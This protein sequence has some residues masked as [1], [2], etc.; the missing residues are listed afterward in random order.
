MSEKRENPFIKKT[1][2]IVAEIFHRGLSNKALDDLSAELSE[3]VEE[4]DPRAAY[5][6]YALKISGLQA[7]DKAEA[8]YLLKS[9]AVAGYAPAQYDL[10]IHYLYGE[11]IEKDFLK[12]VRYMEKAGSQN[13][14][15]AAQK[16]VT[17]YE[18]GTRIA[19]NPYRAEYWR[20]V[21]EGIPAEDLGYLNEVSEEQIRLSSENRRRS[22]IP[23][24]KEKTEQDK[25]VINAADQDDVI[26]ADLN[27]DILVNAGPGTGKTYTLIQRANYIVNQYSEIDADNIIIL[28]FTNAVVNEISARLKKMADEPD[29]RR[30]IRNVGV[31]TFHSLA[32][33]LV[34]MANGEFD[35]NEWTPVD[36]DFNVLNYDSLLRKASELLRGH[37]EITEGWYLI[38]DEI[39]DITNER[40]EFVL[41]LV[42]AVHEHGGHFMLLGDSCQAIYGYTVDKASE[43]SI[44]NREFYDRIRR[45]LSANSIQ[46]EFGTNH[47]STEAIQQVT[48]PLRRTILSRDQGM[49]K[50]TLAL[51]RKNIPGEDR[52]QLLQKLK[53]SAGKDICLLEWSNYDTK[54]VSLMLRKAGIP[55][56]C[57]LSYDKNSYVS[58][59]GRIFS[60]YKEDHIDWN[61]FRQLA[62]D[63]GALQNPEEAWNFFK[64]QSGTSA[65]ILNIRDI[66]NVISDHQKKY[67]VGMQDRHG[68]YVSNIHRAKG[69]EFDAVIVD[70]QLLKNS[71]ISKDDPDEVDEAMRVAY[72]AITRPR[73]S[74]QQVSGFS[75]GRRIPNWSN[76]RKY[77]VEKSKGNSAITS[78]EILQNSRDKEKVGDIGPKEFLLKDPVRFSKAQNSLRG[79]DEHAEVEVRL[80][81]ETGK[82]EVV[83]IRDGVALA[84]MASVFSRDI[85]AMNDWT[86]RTLH[87]SKNIVGLSG[88]YI[89]GIFTYIDRTP[90]GQY[91]IWNYA[92]IS[93]PAEPIYE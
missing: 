54:K 87:N 92:A 79:M 59:I 90:A 9:A 36:L 84:E 49:Y 18:A 83:N 8:L 44:S 93:G 81:R 27:R 23:E 73:E 41:S 58:W 12:A 25:N 38:V 80:N 47:R 10:A 39:Q 57:V 32:N 28:S 31:Y 42:K 29:G 6:L 71:L 68:L 61:T 65:D 66:V 22:R 34:K 26:K 30:E 53:V 1:R 60:G 74:L 85:H 3:G 72:V 45:M 55:H 69:L 86:H 91:Q 46:A 15:E 48:T 64:E 50:E 51:L 43:C 67:C 78:V 24:Q 16:L 88:I 70:S 37:G 33:W 76:R 77:T 63:R 40:A 75:S 56:Q 20:Q 21:A 17:L 7:G 35:E 2:K 13:Y 11:G 89:D 82:F 62:I 52:E 14:F 19:K 5:Q 4:Q